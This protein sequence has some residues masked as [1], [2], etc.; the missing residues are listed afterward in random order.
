MN[1]PTPKTDVERITGRFNTAL[2]FF[3]GE[4]NIN[5]FPNKNRFAFLSHLAFFTGFGSTWAEQLSRSNE[6]FDVFPPKLAPDSWGSNCRI[7]SF[8][9]CPSRI[10]SGYSASD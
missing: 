9:C 1:E 5:S 10:R 6:E 4:K 2:N 3:L 7:Y 8:C